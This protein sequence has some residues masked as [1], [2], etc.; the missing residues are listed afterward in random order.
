MSNPDRLLKEAQEHAQT[1]LEFRGERNAR[2]WIVHCANR[3]T[4]GFW[5]RVLIA[6]EELV[7]EREQEARIAE[8]SDEAAD[9]GDFEFHRDHDQ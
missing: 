5:S 2:E 1:L 7:K 9:R 3:S 6:F 8:E 4:D